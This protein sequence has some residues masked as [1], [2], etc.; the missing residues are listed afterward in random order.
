MTPR[1]DGRASLRRGLGA[2]S[3]L[4]GLCWSSTGTAAIVERVV[5]VVG[6]RA[7]L[8]SDLRERT[9]PFLLRIHSE[10]PP[11]AQRTAAIS[12]AY[13]M[14]LERIVD[15][16][17]QQRA[18]ARA[19]LTVTNQE[20]DNAMA[21]IAAQNGIT[22]DRLL[23]E[24]ASTGMTESQYRSELRRQ[25]IEAKL[26]NV[27]LQGRIRVTEEDL[28]TAYRRIQ[29]D[30]RRKLPFRVA[31]VRIDAPQDSPGV[32]AKRALADRVAE[33]ARQG[34][35]FAALARRHSDD[36]ESRGA[37]GLLPP[38]TPGTLPTALDRAA[39][40]LEL[41][42]V[43]APLR[44]GDALYVLKLVERGA[45]ELPTYEEAREELSER[46]Y[47]EKMNKARRHW[48][49]GLRKRTHVDVRL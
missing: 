28:R 49:D 24:A 40:G 41:G 4:A 10:V 26:L 20:I 21:R 7:I 34:A 1:P 6:D 15:E 31:M 36:A 5:A 39:L 47:M 46:V 3:L 18:A 25:V 30:E 14:V 9:R 38:L 29:L 13:R 17:L 35:D 48:L 8:L 37:G 22:V 11:G 44:H 2:L 33:E 19:R 16:E 12:Q 45:S 23:A 42:D 32:A 43:S 27:R